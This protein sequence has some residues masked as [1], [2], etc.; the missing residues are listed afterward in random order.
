M[1]GPRPDDRDVGAYPSEV[2]GRLAHAAARSQARVG[3]QEAVGEGLRAPGR[4]ASSRTSSG[5]QLLLIRAPIVPRAKLHGEQA[6][7]ELY[8]GAGKGEDNILELEMHGPYETLAP[9]ASM[10]FEQ[11]FEILDY[12]GPETQEG[13][14]AR[15]KALR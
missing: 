8:R 9:G 6:F 2:R 10:S 12:E 7:I 13:H 4:R 15:L 11:T 14:I 3:A 1:D 5:K